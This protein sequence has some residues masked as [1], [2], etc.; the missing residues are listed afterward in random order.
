MQD[1]PTIDE[2]LEAVAGFLSDDDAGYNR[3]IRGARW[4]FVPA[5]KVYLYGLN[6]ALSLLISMGSGNDELIVGGQHLEPL[7]IAHAERDLGR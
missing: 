5:D 6:E 1:R 2:L 7:L 4:E 3:Q